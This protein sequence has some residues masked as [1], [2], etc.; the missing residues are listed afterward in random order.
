MHKDLSVRSCW[1]GALLLLGGALLIRLGVLILTPQSHLSD[2]IDLIYDDGYYYLGIAA[3]LAESGH[4]TL[5][6]ITSTNG[7]QPLWLIVLAGFAKIVGTQTHTFFVA[8]CALLYV[9]ALC[10]PLVAL[11]WRR[12]EWRI[13]A[14]C[15]GTGVGIVVIQQPGVF[16]EG[17]EPV[18]FAPLI[19]PL[20]LFIERADENRSLLALSAV[21]AIAFLI[22][23][24]ALAL[25]VSTVAVLPLL[26][27][28]TKTIRPQ[29]WLANTFNL[30]L[31][32]SI[33]VVP[34]VLIYA[35]VNQALFD[36]PIP[37]S[38][39]AKL[40]GGPRFAN[41]GVIEM[42]FTRWRPLALLILV[43][44]PLEFLTR[45]AH[46][47]PRPFFYR[48]FAV[49][50]VAMSIQAFY[51]AA[52]ST[53]NVWPWYAY[54]VAVAMAL[55]IARI[56]YLTA[57]LCT[58]ER[59]RSVAIGVLVLL[60]AWAGHR[61]AAFAYRSLPG[62]LQARLSIGSQLK[63][64]PIKDSS[65]L[66]FNQVS[67]LMLNEFFTEPTRT[68][69]AMGDRAGGLAYWGRGNVAVIQAEGL[70]L[71]K[72]YLSARA[73]Q[74]GE[75]YFEQLPIRD[76]VVDRE[77][78]ATITRED[79]TLEYAIPEPIQGR[80]T[81]EPVPTFCFP[82]SAIRY[83]K[84]YASA[85]GVNTRIAFSFDE[86]TPCS[87][88]VLAIVREAERGMGLRQFSLP[89][90]YRSELGGTMDKESEDRDRHFRPAQ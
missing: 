29:Q 32:L 6:G 20:V 48:A 24:D 76:W 13:P 52:F 67:L 37:V 72:A 14:L 33:F 19:V 39:V 17:L 15:I 61:A 74:Q 80:V 49:V 28:L 25:F 69:V 1:Y 82:Q 50:A 84:Q 55:V 38:G 40:L 86:R 71:D 31:R 51:Y 56:V 7:Y 34:T 89:T 58:T 30:G 21:L 83:S 27:L 41:W 79:G 54:L 12:G 57:L 44:L 81:N 53:W 59:L 8:S 77:F 64:G 87:N 5:D 46:L 43:M 18:L 4:S 68:T 2:V 23:L 63:L 90:E 16:L 26:A 78:F 9:I 66:S 3:N 75:H 11:T 47:S 70:T 22:R 65:T 88:D 60:F 73:Q 36:S 62:D 85:W 42:F 35:A 45:Q 10:G